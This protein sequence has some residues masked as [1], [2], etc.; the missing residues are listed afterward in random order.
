MSH[1]YIWIMCIPEESKYKGSEVEAWLVGSRNIKE[2]SVGGTEG[3]RVE[4]RKR[5]SGNSCTMAW[6]A[7]KTLAFILSR[8]KSY[9]R[10]WGSGATQSAL[11]L[12]KITQAD[13]SPTGGRGTTMKAEVE[14]YCNDSGERRSWLGPGQQCRGSETGTVDGI[15]KGYNRKRGIKIRFRIFSQ[16]TGTEVL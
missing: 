2:V 4:D 7:Q 9:W 12:K 16:S 5:D 11:C 15:D 6:K 1:A 8:A 14:H 3:V 13:I 10:I